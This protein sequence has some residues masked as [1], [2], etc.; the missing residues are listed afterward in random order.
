M[1]NKYGLFYFRLLLPEIG[2]SMSTPEIDMSGALEDI[3][4]DL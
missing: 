1:K 3:M 4:K 2:D